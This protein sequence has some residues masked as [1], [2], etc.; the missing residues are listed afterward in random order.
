MPV[1]A[2]HC[3]ALSLARKNQ[4]ERLDGSLPDSKYSAVE[5]GEDSRK[6][7]YTKSST[8]R[9]KRYLYVFGVAR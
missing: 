3:I 8:G 2:V 7:T 4:A 5:V 1:Y 6:R 9:H